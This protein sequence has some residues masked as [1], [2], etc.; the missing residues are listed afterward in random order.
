LILPCWSSHVGAAVGSLIHTLNCSQVRLL[1][2]TL[3]SEMPILSKVEI[4]SPC[5]STLSNVV[6]VVVMVQSKMSG[7]WGVEFVVGEFEI[8]DP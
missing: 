2:W 5:Y 1:L 6:S 8:L 4:G 7:S 3:V